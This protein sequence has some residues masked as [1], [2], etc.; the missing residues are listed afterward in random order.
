[1]NRETFS[2]YSFEIKNWRK[3]PKI[4]KTFLDKG[5]VDIKNL[6]NKWNAKNNICILTKKMTFHQSK[7]KFDSNKFKLTKDKI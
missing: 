5:Y 3:N 7:V 2:L 1:M 4:R 6:W